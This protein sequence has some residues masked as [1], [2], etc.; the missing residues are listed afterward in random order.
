M[1]LM[2][3]NHV[4]EGIPISNSQTSGTTN[5][6][7]SEFTTMQALFS[8]KAH[9]TCNQEQFNTMQQLFGTVNNPQS[10]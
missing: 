1:Q 6:N 5:P 7:A 2:S 4:S 10:T 3:I 8:T 9:K